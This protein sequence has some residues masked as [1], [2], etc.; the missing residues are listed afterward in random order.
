[1]LPRL[2]GAQAILEAIPEWQSTYMRWLDSGV[3]LKRFQEQSK[4]CNWPYWRQH[5]TLA[6]DLGVFAGACIWLDIAGA[7]QAAHLA[8]T[9]RCGSPTAH[10]GRQGSI[11]CGH[12][13]A[14]NKQRTRD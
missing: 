13:Q 1:M 7:L 10:P 2:Q 8:V 14:N 5:A 3:L 11:N 4:H 9:G 12:L 6:T